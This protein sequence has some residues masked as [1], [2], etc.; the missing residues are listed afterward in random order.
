M[1]ACFVIN[2]ASDR[3]TPAYVQNVVIHNLELSGLAWPGLDERK[4]MSYLSILFVHKGQRLSQLTQIATRF[5]SVVKAVCSAS[6]STAKSPS[7]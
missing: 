7:K 5:T 1:V 2:M 4:A 6:W 3:V